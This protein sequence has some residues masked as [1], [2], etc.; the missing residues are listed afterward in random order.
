MSSRP[1]WQRWLLIAA[2][3]VAVLF[4]VFQLVGAAKQVSRVFGHRQDAIAPW[5]TMGHVARL[6]RVPPRQARV[7]ARPRGR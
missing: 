1:N 2:I 5:M 4:S 7:S 6:H 3:V